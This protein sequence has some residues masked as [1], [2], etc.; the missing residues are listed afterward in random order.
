MNNNC[1]LNTAD[2]A[3][4]GKYGW[5]ASNYHNGL[6]KI[7]LETGELEFVDVFPDEDFT[8]YNLIAGIYKYHDQ[9]FCIPRVGKQIY[10][11]HLKE[12][13]FSTIKLLRVEYSSINSEVNKFF[14]VASYKNCLYLI[15]GYYP[16]ILK[17]NLDTLQIDKKIKLLFEDREDDSSPFFSTRYRI[18]GD[19]LYLL[20]MPG[21]RILE[22]DMERD[23]Y[24]VHLL[25]EGERSYT[26]VYLSQNTLLFAKYEGSITGWDKATH[27][28]EVSN[29]NIEECLKLTYN[30]GIFREIVNNTMLLI[31]DSG[32]SIGKI[33]IGKQPLENQTF[34]NTLI[35]YLIQNT[36]NQ[37]GVVKY[38]A[39]QTIILIPRFENKIVFIYI[40]NDSVEWKQIDVAAEDELKIRELKVNNI[41]VEDQGFVLKDMIYALQKRNSKFDIKESE[42]ENKQNAGEII[43]KAIMNLFNQNNL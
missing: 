20:M 26:G 28:I 24:K 5:F 15:P 36:E 29:K 30:Q 9:L 16:Y 31:T 10:I 34:L 1:I 8:K 18:D 40:D 7:N 12:A 32:K 23:E 3:I 6:Y 35:M 17:L 27:D 22:L 38:I 11:Y 13:T 37:F 2:I 41:H 4:E 25:E 21:F 14:G 19:K 39:E 33:N 42:I 43:H